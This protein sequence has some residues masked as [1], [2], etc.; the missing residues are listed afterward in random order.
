MQAVCDGV[1][2]EVEEG[3]V[4]GGHIV[5]VLGDPGGS[6]DSVREGGAAW[7]ERG[8]RRVQNPRGR[9]GE[10]GAGRRGGCGRGRGIGL[11]GGQLEVLAAVSDARGVGVDM[12]QR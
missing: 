12:G 6:D 5:L 2:G 9:G 10:G 4:Y 7:R 11:L 3:D 1:G 8:D